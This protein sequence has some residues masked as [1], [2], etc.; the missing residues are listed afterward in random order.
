MLSIFEAIGNK[1]WVVKY[2]ENVDHGGCSILPNLFSGKKL[3]DC[4][5]LKEGK[6]EYGKEVCFMMRIFAER[7]ERVGTD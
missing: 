3:R 1:A 5:E 4:E 6:M 7:S 2:G